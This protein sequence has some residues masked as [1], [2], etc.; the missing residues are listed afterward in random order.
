ME[1]LAACAYSSNGGYGC[2]Q[3]ATGSVGELQGREHLINSW[4][5]T[6]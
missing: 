6:S 5:E 3:P 4:L 2:K 1:Q